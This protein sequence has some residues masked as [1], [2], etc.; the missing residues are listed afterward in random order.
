MIGHVT[1]GV[2]ATD[3]GARVHTVLVDTGEVTGTHLVDTGEVTG[4]LGVYDTLRLTLNVRVAFVV[5]DTGT[6]GG[7]TL[8]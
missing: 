6:A 4:T 2:V 8:L 1:R 3:P 7:Q 5:P